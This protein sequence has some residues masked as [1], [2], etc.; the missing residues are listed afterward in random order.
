MARFVAIPVTV[1]DAYFL[2][3][4]AGSVL[5]DGG[6]NR[7]A[8]PELFRQSTRRSEVDILVVTHNDADHTN[9]VAGFLDAGLTCKEIW[10]PGRWLDVLPE[11]ANDPDAAFD[12]VIKQGH[13]FWVEHSKDFERPPSIQEVGDR[14]ARNSEDEYVAAEFPEAGE[15]PDE[16]ADAM[17]AE[18]IFGGEGLWGDGEVTLSEVILP[19]MQKSPG[20]TLVEQ[21]IRAGVRILEIARL[22]YFNGIPVRWFTHAPDAPAGG[23]HGFLE[24]VTARQVVRVFSRRSLFER[25]CLS[26]ANVESLVFYSP[27]DAEA[28]GV[29][30]TTDSDLQLASVPTHPHDVVTTPHHGSHH[31]ARAYTSILAPVLKH[32]QNTVTWVRSDRRSKSRPCGA[33]QRLHARKI[34]TICSS[35]EAK[36]KI[37]LIG[38]QQR[39]ARHPTVRICKC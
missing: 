12:D 27:A 33:Y 26:T 24:P 34:C 21:A 39:W 17:E 18:E 1:G 11:I 31:N 22:A 37:I 30:F 3:R 28:P 36:Q 25:L 13:E 7:A 20:W 4:T 38:R 29:L 2:E 9:G 23:I 32:E 35:G 6:M 8:F 15:W 10:L 14:L 19:W 5:V 16:V